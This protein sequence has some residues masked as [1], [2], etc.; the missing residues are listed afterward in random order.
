MRLWNQFISKLAD[1]VT[2]AEN[3]DTIMER[4]GEDADIDALIAA[5]TNILA[6]AADATPLG[7]LADA[8]TTLSALAADASDITAAADRE[9][10]ATDGTGAITGTNTSVTIAH[11][12]A[13]TPSIYQ[14]K[15]IPTNA[16]MAVGGWY[17]TGV[18]SANFVVNIPTAPGGTDEATFAW[19]VQ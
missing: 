19:E 7:T 12:Y 15:I 2:L 3:K 8:Q 1:V 14:I 18:G 4:V 10:A 5:K 16:F 13:T 9:D 6:V 17:I 11:G